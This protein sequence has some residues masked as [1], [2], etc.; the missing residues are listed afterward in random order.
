[1]IDTRP[2]GRPVRFLAGRFIF[3][4]WLAAASVLAGSGIA[5]AAFSTIYRFKTG[6][7]GARPTGDLT[8]VGNN[9]LYGTTKE[10]GS[11][12][13]P[14]GC[15]T[16]FQLALPAGQTVWRETV[17]Y[18]FKVGNDGAAPM[19]GLVR[20]SGGVLYGT[21]SSGGGASSSG[22][23]TVFRL[24]PPAAAGQP[25]TEAVIYN[26]PTGPDGAGPQSDLV[27]DSAGRIYGTTFQGQFGVT[28]GTA[29][30]LRPPAAGQTRWLYT[31]L[32]GLSSADGTFP[33]AGLILD[34]AGNTLYGTTTANGPLGR[35][36]I[37]SLKRP[38]TGTAW[39]FKVIHAFPG[40]GSVAFPARARLF[41]S[42]GVLYGVA[43]SGIGAQTRG[44]VFKLLPPSGTRTTWLKANLHIFNS[45]VNGAGPV[46]RLLIRSGVIYG[47]TR[48][49]GNG[50]GTVFKIT[51]TTFAVLHR[52]TG[53]AGGAK[54]LAGLVADTAGNLYGTTS[55]GGTANRGTV[56]RITP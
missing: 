17:L 37:F 46:G 1:M 43:E 21:T 3:T 54:P 52:F 10:G 39:P 20:R 42:G 19:A 9:L 56:F 32:R 49:G 45:D 8:T 23:G 51:G 11:C 55:E 14:Q 28:F 2:L 48:D 16:V 40:N 7:D 36:T 12:S 47:T 38:T 6:T 35:S 24:T 13:F 50:F 27:F 4:A 29:F 33:T 25:W 26:F 15:G 53:G 31:R 22:E 5:D 30:Q 34:P 18:R 44:T 41:L